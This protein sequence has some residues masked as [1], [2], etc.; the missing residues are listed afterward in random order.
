PVGGTA[1]QLA[2]RGAEL[3]RLRGHLDAALDG[4]P[5]AVFLSGE[6]GQGKTALLTAFADMAQRA[7]PELVVA[8]GAGTATAGYGDPF[9]AV[10]DVF[11]MLVA[12][13]RAGWQVDQ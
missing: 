2:G 4:R 10:R 11:R 3:D 7:V 5:R 13:P 1:D 8:R 9:L 12:D 6:A